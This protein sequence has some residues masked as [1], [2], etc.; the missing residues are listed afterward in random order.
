MR[1]NGQSASESDVSGF[2]FSPRGLCPGKRVVFVSRRQSEL[3]I[4]GYYYAVV[5]RRKFTISFNK[6]KKKKKN[7]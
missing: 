1:E 3:G 4:R 6:I 2:F 7:Q 5:H